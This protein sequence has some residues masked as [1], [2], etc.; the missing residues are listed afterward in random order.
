MAEAGFFSVQADSDLVK[1]FACGIEIQNW[2]KSSDD[3][4][5]IHEKQNPDCLYLKIKGSYS[6]ELTVKEFLEIEKY[7]C[8][9]LNQKHFEKK[10]KVI[11]EV[12]NIM[13]NLDSDEEIELTVDENNEV[14][15]H[16]VAKK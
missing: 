14:Q 12:V 16:A 2:S 15:I 6:N 8:L 7:R 5:S 9:N 10:T 4:W 1:C 11:K 3:P 13:Q